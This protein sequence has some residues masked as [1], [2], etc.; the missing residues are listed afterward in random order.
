MHN[1]VLF[2]VNRSI[3]DQSQINVNLVSALNELT[4]TVQAQQDEIEQL[5]AEVRR[6]SE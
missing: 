2:Y 3:R 5:R 1:L 6:H 4:R